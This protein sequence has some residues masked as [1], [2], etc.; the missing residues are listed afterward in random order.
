VLR[1]FAVSGPGPLVTDAPVDRLPSLLSDPDTYVW[2]DLTS[3][4]AP[5]EQALLRD[6][7][8]FHPLA[9]EDC[10]GVRLHPKIDE[11]EEYLYIITH[12]LKAGSTAEAIQPD[13]LDVFLGAR[14]LVTHHAEDSRSVAQVIQ[15]LLKAGLPLRRGPVAVLHA[16]LDRQVDGLEVVID[17]V[18]LRIEG[19][20]D[21]VFDRPAN[22]PIAT[23]LSVKRS[24][25]Q[26]RRWMSKQR[27]VVLRLGRQEFP[28]IPARD[29]LLF[30][31]VYDHLVRI[32]DLLEN[33]REMLTSVQDAHL[34]VT[35]NRLNEVMKF[36]TV[37][38]VLFGPAT[39]IAGIY[40][41]NFQHMPEIGWHWGYPVTLG[42][43]VGVEAAALLYF[44]RRGWIGRRDE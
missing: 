10:V 38:T 1:I 17:D 18:E 8:E 42:L 20:E 26:L 9:I 12:G 15:I 39:L 4:I 6:V 44:W 7:F 43:M 24:I 2:V 19:L 3:P 36:L 13:E 27:D 30:R 11:F 31:D 41:M 40:G 34:A 14:Y 32:N 21:A 5:E 35:S 16:L 23:L 22:T 37:C 29:A 28:E 25:L 33:F